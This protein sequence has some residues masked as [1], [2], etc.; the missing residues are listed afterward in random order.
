MNEPYRM[1]AGVGFE[2]TRAF[3]HKRFQGAVLMTAWI[4][5][6]IATLSQWPRPCFA[7]WRPIKT[8][9]KRTRPLERARRIELPPSDWKSEVLPLNYARM[10]NSAAVLPRF[11]PSANF[12][13]ARS[14]LPVSG[15]LRCYF[16][17]FTDYPCLRTLSS[18]CRSLG[19]PQ[20]PSGLQMQHR[21]SAC[22]PGA[23]AAVP[24]DIPPGSS[25]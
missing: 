7:F 24:P 21:S 18:L 10:K 1:A 23:P 17:S 22:L 2:P 6:Q 20:A 3:A 9:T 19:C 16:S 5:R 4:A 12:R 15:R 14:G 11:C 8:R 25:S 13:R